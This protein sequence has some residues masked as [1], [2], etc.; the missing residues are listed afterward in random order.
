MYAFDFGIGDGDWLLHRYDSSNTAFSP[1]GLAEWQFVSASCTTVNTI[2]NCIVTN[3]YDHDVRDVK[4]KLS[5]NINANWYNVFGN[6]LK[7]ESNYYI[8][9]NLSSLSTLTFIITTAEIHQPEKPTINGSSYGKV[10]EEYTYVVS[11]VDPNNREISYYIDWGDGT[12]TEWT[13]TMPSGKPLNV[14]HIWREKGS[15][16]IKAK[17]KNIEG[18]ESEWS[19]PLPVSMPKSKPLPSFL[20]LC[21]SIIFRFFSFMNKPL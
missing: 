5:D 11:A 21:Y 3:A 1:N 12:F 17:A 13:G 20:E 7:P 18:I 15:Y 14:S 6:L 16:I 8:I 9:E 4:L 19:D 10:G 2:T